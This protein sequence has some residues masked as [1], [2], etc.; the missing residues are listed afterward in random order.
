MKK[1]LYLRMLRQ[2]YI[3]YLLPVIVIG[4]LYL[5]NFKCLQNFDILVIL[6]MHLPMLIQIIALNSFLRRSYH[7]EEIREQVN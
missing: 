4:I 1:R 3:V 6:A 7:N 5:I 2:F